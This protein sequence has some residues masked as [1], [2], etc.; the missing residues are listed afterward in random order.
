SDPDRPPDSRPPHLCEP[1][2]RRPVGQRQNDEQC[3]EQCAHPPPP[4]FEHPGANCTAHTRPASPDPPR[5]WRRPSAGS[6]SSAR[7]PCRVTTRTT[8][9]EMQI[10]ATF[11]QYLTI[12]TS[13]Y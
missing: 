8:L 2:R 12:V 4:G 10:M 7:S 5:R 3:P 6:L 13:Y 9:G 11:M 1:L